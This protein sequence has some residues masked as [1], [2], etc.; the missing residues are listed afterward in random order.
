MTKKSIRKKCPASDIY[1]D[2]SKLDRLRRLENCEWIYSIFIELP[3][4][5]NRNEMA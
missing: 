3:P 2:L 5:V 1:K 4:G